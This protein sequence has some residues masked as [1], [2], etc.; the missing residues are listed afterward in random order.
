MMKEDVETSVAKWFPNVFKYVQTKGFNKELAPSG[1]PLPWFQLL[2]QSGMTGTVVEA[3]YPT[4]QHLYQHKG[5]SKA[6]VAES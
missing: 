6:S 1:I 4:G 3:V 5:H 2:S